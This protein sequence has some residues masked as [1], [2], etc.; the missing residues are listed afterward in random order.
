MIGFEHLHFHDRTVYR[1]TIPPKEMYELSNN[2]VYMKFVSLRS[3]I[4]RE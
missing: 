3:D 4:G 1:F 2:R